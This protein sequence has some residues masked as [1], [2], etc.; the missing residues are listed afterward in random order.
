MTLWSPGLIY[1]DLHF[2]FVILELIRLDTHFTLNMVLKII[3]IYGNMVAP[4]F[5]Q[6]L[7]TDLVS[8]NMAD[9]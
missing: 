7:P 1:I 8:D 9:M 3:F 6:R 4:A 2:Y 5:P